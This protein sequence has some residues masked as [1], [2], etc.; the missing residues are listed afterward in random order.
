MFSVDCTEDCTLYCSHRQ[1]S[2]C[3]GRQVVVMFT[4]L[5]LLICLYCLYSFTSHWMIIISSIECHILT[6]CSPLTTSQLSCMQITD[7]S[8]SLHSVGGRK[9]TALTW[10][11]IDQSDRNHGNLTLWAQTDK[12]SV[13][14]LQYIL[15]Y[16]I[17]FL[18]VSVGH[19]TKYK[20]NIHGCDIFF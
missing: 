8:R 3:Q 11:N 16:K 2:I 6:Q 17:Q 13:N 20:S 1:F 15:W 14:G 5:P 18:S 9:T 10:H 19:L 4:S 12:Q 7:Y